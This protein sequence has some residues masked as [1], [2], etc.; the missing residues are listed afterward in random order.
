MR[1]RIPLTIALDRDSRVP[2]YRQLYDALRDAIARG[3]LASGAL[4]PSTRWLARRLGVSKQVISRYEESE[5]QTV[6]IVRLQEI[7]DAIG[8]KA[9]VSLS[10]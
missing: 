3:G 6:S 4:L 8:V 10:A 1:H 7:L 9:L 2:L 5:Y